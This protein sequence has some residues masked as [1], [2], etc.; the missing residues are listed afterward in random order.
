MWYVSYV[1]FTTYCRATVMT[2]LY[3]KRLMFMQMFC[4]KKKKMGRHNWSLLVARMYR[5]K[6]QILISGCRNPGHSL[7]SSNGQLPAPES[8]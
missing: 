4:I 3:C 2:R 7:D 8:G 1:G 5:P 6:S